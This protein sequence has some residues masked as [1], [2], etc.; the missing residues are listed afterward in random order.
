MIQASNLR[1]RDLNGLSDP[2]VKL[3][4]LPGRGSVTHVTVIILLHTQPKGA[5]IVP[6]QA[7]ARR[8]SRLFAYTK[9]SYFMKNETVENVYEIFAQ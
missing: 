8:M 9:F 1:P 5:H 2:F 6:L 3:Y 4:L 7:E